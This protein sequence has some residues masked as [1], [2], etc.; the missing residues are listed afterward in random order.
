[1]NI[2]ENFLNKISE[3]SLYSSMQDAKKLRMIGLNEK[4]IEKIMKLKIK[5]LLDFYYAEIQ[6][7][8]TSIREEICE[9]FGPDLSGII[10]E[11]D[12]FLKF[13]DYTKVVHLTI[14]EI[15]NFYI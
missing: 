1:M 9:I 8:I 3:L 10:C 7:I 11:Y 2:N 12:E 5:M 14:E 4:S 15:A 6:K 13:G